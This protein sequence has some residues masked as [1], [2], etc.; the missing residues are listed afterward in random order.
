[1]EAI[2]KSTTAVWDKRAKMMFSMKILLPVP[3]FSAW[4]TFKALHRSRSWKGWFCHMS[5][6]DVH[7]LES[8]RIAIWILPYVF[9]NKLN[10]QTSMRTRFELA[11]RYVNQ[12]DHR[13]WPWTRNYTTWCHIWYFDFVGS[14][15]IVSYWCVPICSQLMIVQ[16]ST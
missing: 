11:G 4:Y 9:K 1:M 8:L 6:V 13:K 14:L 10:L 5:L 15:V 7:H 16:Y 3:A 2:A 12:G